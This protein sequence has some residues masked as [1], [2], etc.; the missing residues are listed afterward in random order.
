MQQG[1]WPVR[2]DLPPPAGYTSVF[3]YATYPVRFRAFMQDRARIE[4]LKTQF[5]H[6]IGP[7]QG[8]NPTEV[9]GL[10]PVGR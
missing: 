10:Y 4:R 2:R 1:R 3:D 5:E 8:P 9:K 6:Y 7:A